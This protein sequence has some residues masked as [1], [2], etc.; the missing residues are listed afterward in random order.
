[1][2]ACSGA[3]GVEAEPQAPCSWP[4]RRQP[5]LRRGVRPHGRR[6]DPRRGAARV[7]AGHHRRPPRHVARRREGAPPGRGRDRQGLLG[8]GAS[9]REHGA[10]A[11]RFTRSNAGVIRCARTASA[12]AGERE[13]AFRHALVRDV[14][15]AQIPRAQ[16]A[17][18]HR[19]AAPMDRIAGSARGPRGDARAPLRRRLSTTRAAAG[20]DEPGTS[21]RARRICLRRAGDRASRSRVRGHCGFYASALESG[22][23]DDPSA[24]TALRLR[25]RCTST[26]RQR[27][28]N[29]RGSRAGAARR[30]RPRASGR[31]R[32]LPR[33]RS[34][35]SPG[36]RARSR[37]LSTCVTSCQ[38][39]LGRRR[40]VLSQVARYRMLAGRER[41]R[42]P[43]RPGGA[44]YRRGARSP[45]ARAHALNNIGPAQV[46]HGDK[47]PRRHR[48]V[49]RD[50]APIASP[51]PRA[52]STTSA[53]R[54]IRRRPRA[55]SSAHGGG[56][57]IGE[58]IGNA[59]LG[60][61]IDDVSGSGSSRTGRGTSA[62]GHRPL[63]RGRQGAALPRSR[64]GSARHDPGSP[65]ATPTARSE[66][67]DRA[68]K[69]PA[70]RRAGDPQ[71]PDGVA[72]RL[73]TWVLVEGERV[74]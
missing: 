74:D 71:K 69:T 38:P 1:M 33:P 17:E 41:G 20:T 36:R 25:T 10:R 60:R 19:A 44:R 16:R 23:T 15:Y 70:A 47:R 40:D 34:G 37:A 14:A 53:R 2:H 58:R 30:R 24:C 22:R 67:S 21:R 35:W 65:E 28:G 49:P 26:G 7:G 5:A 61:F 4:S 59:D 72:R 43:Y 9:A 56:P 64:R 8:G 73:P 18:K 31:D 3:P 54:G 63:P 66:T 45:G 57:E 52:G 39:T 13:Y 62:G 29:A 46:N 12:V 48:A 51:G 42:D 32:G 6:G 11:E 55:A 50:R 68:S 27:R